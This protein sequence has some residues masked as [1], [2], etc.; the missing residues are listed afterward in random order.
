MEPVKIVTRLPSPVGTTAGSRVASSAVQAELGGAPWLQ[1]GDE[2]VYVGRQPPWAGMAEAASRAGGGL[3][4]HPCTIDR[5]RLHVII[6]KGRLFQH[7]HPGVAV[8]IDRGR[9]LLVD[10]DPNVAQQLAETKQPCYSVRA[11]DRLE[12]NGEIGEN[13]IV[14]EARDRGTDRERL[15]AT[16]PAVQSLVDRISR[17]TF[18]ANLT[19]LVGFPTRFSTG[20][21]YREVC[22]FVE[23]QFRLLGYATSR[24]TISVNGA[25]SA[26][27]IARRPGT[28]P[29]PRDAVLMSAHL[30]SLN[31]EGTASSPAPGADDDG[32]GSAGVLEIARVLNGQVSTHDLVLVL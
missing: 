7:E 24:Q 31:H 15:R 27:V 20:T 13:R 17:A 12:A 9:Y 3:R 16:H 2:F 26:N 29:E 28:G 30:D 5:A 25:P 14:F 19:R 11:L 4:E 32:S 8:I 10:M 21:P 6:Q 23:Q 18:E 22:D 1:F